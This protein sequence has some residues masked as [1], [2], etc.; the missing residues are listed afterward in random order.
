MEAEPL[1]VFA[2]RAGRAPRGAEPPDPTAFE[3]APARFQARLRATLAAHGGRVFAPRGETCA[4]AFDAPAAALAA[5]RAVLAAP[6]DELP[7]RA[8]AALH[9]GAAVERD[10]TPSGTG[11]YRGLVLLA[12]AHA[13]QA[14]VSPAAAERLRG[15]L[16]AGAAL[17]ELG[18]FRL[19]DARQPETLYQLAAPELA[20]RFPRPRTADQPHSNLPLKAPE[21][22]GR[23]RDAAVQARGCAMRARLL[24][25]IGPG[26]AG[27][28][29]L[30]VLVAVQLRDEFAAGAFFVPLAPVNNLGLLVST[31]ARA[32]GAREAPDR[33]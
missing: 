2:D 24:T 5:A 22:I 31:L 11:V 3:R 23:K 32:I 16:P 8:C 15:A 6:Q 19:G 10:G 12:A 25:L 28:T 30:S 29:R 13:G 1:F 26:G 4:A 14:L 27:K 33:C 21:L 18:A 9:A 7:L 17:R 20:A